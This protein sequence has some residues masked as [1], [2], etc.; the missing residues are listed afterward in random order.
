MPNAYSIGLEIF[1]IFFSTH[2]P[3]V[4][5]DCFG[6]E[7]HSLYPLLSFS[8][9]I[10]YARY[11]YILLWRGLFLSFQRR[12][13]FIFVALTLIK[14]F[15]LLYAYFCLSIAHGW[16]LNIH[17]YCKN[18]FFFFGKETN[19]IIFVHSSKFFFNFLM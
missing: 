2:P 19:E 12:F 10:K 11:P 17:R 3:E 6:N 15:P 4:V 18:D 1:W 9:F 16:I 7:F 8:Y 13:F 5:F 14:L